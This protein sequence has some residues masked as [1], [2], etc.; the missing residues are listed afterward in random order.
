VYKLLGIMIAVYLN[1][2]NKDYW[3]Y[4]CIIWELGV[5]VYQLLG[6]MIAVY[7]NIGHNHSSVCMCITWELGVYVYQLLGIMIAVY[8]NIVM[9]QVTDTRTHP[10]P[11]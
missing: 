2:G 4:T 5:Y 10:I 8:L 9:M 6:V 1:I 3:V 11:M 7:L